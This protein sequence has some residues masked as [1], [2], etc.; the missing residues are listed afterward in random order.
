MNLLSKAEMK[1]VKGGQNIAFCTNHVVCDDQNGGYIDFWA[2]CCQDWQDAT[3]WCQGMGYTNGMH[4][5]VPGEV[6]DPE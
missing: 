6:I 5:C 2:R 4:G 3:N 1:N